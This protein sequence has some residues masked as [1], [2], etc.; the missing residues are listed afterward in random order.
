MFWKLKIKTAG[1]MELQQIFKLNNKKERRAKKPVENRGNEVVIL[2]QIVNVSDCFDRS[3]HGFIENKLIQVMNLGYICTYEMPS[4]RP[5]T[6]EAVQI[7][8]SV[9]SPI[10]S[11][12]YACWSRVYL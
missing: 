1:K 7:L 5:S 2:F 10:I 12:V 6:S 3:L 9:K 8:E 4:R 11:L